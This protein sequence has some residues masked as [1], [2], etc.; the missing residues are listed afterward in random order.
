M[1]FQGDVIITDPMYI[2]P[3]DSEADWHDCEYGENMEVLGVHTY[4]THDRGDCAG[5][6]LL[7][8]DLFEQGI[9]KKKGEF[10]HDS[11]MV[12]VMLLSEVLAYNPAALDELGKH[13]YTVI[14]DFDGEVTVEEFD[15]DPETCEHWRFRFKGNKHLI[16]GYCE[17]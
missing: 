12:S 3:Y 14:Q 8:G 9:R 15:E 16:T 11:C 2:I 4:I 7:D 5:Q 10:C 1:K 17:E 13:C 6:D